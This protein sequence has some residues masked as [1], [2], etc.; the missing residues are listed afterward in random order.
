M[1]EPDA[2]KMAAWMEHALAL[3]AR[4][5]F[6]ASP[7]PMVGAVVLDAAGQLAGE[8]YHAR[9]GGPHAE[10][11]ALHQAGERARGGTLVVTLE[12][13]THHGKTPPCTDAIVAAGIRRVLVA[14]RDP[15]R[16]AA[17][18]VEHLR[19][20]GVNVT[21]GR[22][23]NGARRL[24]RRWLTF[25]E[26]RRPWVTMKAAV[27]LDGRIATRTGESQWITGE[28]ARR[29]G[30][31]LREEHDAILVG[32][33][34]LLAD[35]PH[36]TRRLG[37]N[38]SDSWWRVV[39][40]SRLRTPSSARVLTSSPERTVIAHTTAATAEDRQRLE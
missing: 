37:L 6:G 31:E 38:P 29:R 3:A 19:A 14:M 21:V 11:A 39:L 24:N 7:N 26:E 13:C 17:G 22:D 23:A 18:R 4:G 40:D 36:L 35:D 2:E 33:N 16:E 27:S 34:T 5:R 1:S 9:Y 10:I 12:P 28:A 15:H 20:E 25:I 8:G 32:V 30:L